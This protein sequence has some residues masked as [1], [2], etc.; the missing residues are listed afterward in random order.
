MFDLQLKTFDREAA[1]GNPAAGAFIRSCLGMRAESPT[2]SSDA[3]HV[4]PARASRRRTTDRR[5]D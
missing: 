4:V 2:P 1:E 3:W 5:I